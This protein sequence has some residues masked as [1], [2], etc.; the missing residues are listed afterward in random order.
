[1]CWSSPT[2]FRACA[3]GF[4][5]GWDIWLDPSTLLP[6]FT[7]CQ[8]LLCTG[9]RGVG[10]RGACLARF[11][12]VA[13]R[14]SD[15]LSCCT[16]SQRQTAPL[17]RQLECCARRHHRHARR[18]WESEAGVKFHR[19]VPNFVIQAGDFTHGSLLRRVHGVDKGSTCTWQRLDRGLRRRDG[20]RV[21]VWANFSR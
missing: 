8:G 18:V 12:Y 5:H 19:I 20:R 3:A 4:V 6:A 2:L 9:G 1:M 7:S 11:V 15:Q 14:L 13:H 16:A 10:K 21:R 17:Q